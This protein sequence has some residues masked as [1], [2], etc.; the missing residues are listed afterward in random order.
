MLLPDTGGC[1]R[2]IQAQILHPSRTPCA[3]T[4]HICRLLL[5]TPGSWVCPTAL[6]ASPTAAD[7]SRVQTAPPSRTIP[8]EP[9]GCQGVFRQAAGSVSRLAKVRLFTEPS[10]TGAHQQ[11]SAHPGN[12]VSALGPLSAPNASPS[13]P[14]SPST[15]LG[16]SGC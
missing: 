1:Y 16:L 8:E 4:P 11:I 15:L 6:P 3:P 10:V 12:G 7:P 2:V 13:W 14:T 9:H 5:P